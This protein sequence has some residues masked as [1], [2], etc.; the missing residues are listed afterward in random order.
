MASDGNGQDPLANMQNLMGYAGLV[1]PNTYLTFQGK[2]PFGNDVA[3]G[4]PGFGQYYTGS[5]GNMP[6]TNA[7]GQPIQSFVNANNTAQQQYQQQQA[8]YQKALAAY[9]AG[10]GSGAPGTTLNNTGAG[11]LPQAQ[12]SALGQ[13]GPAIS[14]LTQNAAAAQAAMTPQQQ[15]QQSQNDAM[16]NQMLQ[17]QAN[18]SSVQA[19]NGGFGNM[20]GGAFN[21]GSYMPMQL[22]QAPAG[23][24][25]SGGPAPPT[26]PSQ[27][28]MRQA[29]LDALS[30]PGPL[31]QYGAGPPQAG[32]TRTGSVQTPSVM[33]AFLNANQGNSTPYLNTL[34]GLGDLFK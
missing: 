12:Q 30:N 9:N 3:G 27:P 33:T 26:A 2:L 32:Q 15:Y 24:A 14:E 10:G 34:R 8:A 23:A 22:P 11:G 18:M 6:P 25:S 5:G 28:N 7:Q 19:G 13:W 31:P 16:R 17:Q 29:Y 1:D 4:A 21:S 20:P